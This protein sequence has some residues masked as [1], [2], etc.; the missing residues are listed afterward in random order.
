MIT[1]ATTI[2]IMMIVTVPFL[3]L[4]LLL[5][6]IKQRTDYLRSTIFKRSRLEKAHN[7]AGTLL[8]TNL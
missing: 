8:P 3:A 4:L 1:I 5:I 6:S 7:D 2:L